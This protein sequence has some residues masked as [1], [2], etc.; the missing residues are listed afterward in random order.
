MAEPP[1]PPFQTDVS[2]QARDDLARQPELAS[3]ANAVILRAA[4]E[5]R[6][7]LESG[8]NQALDVH[9]RRERL[10]VRV[11]LVPPDTMRIEGLAPG[12]LIPDGA[13]TV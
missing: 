7:R 5:L 6:A 10:T 3:S 1:P 8:E 9:G 11:S 13:L 2:E 12:D 4:K